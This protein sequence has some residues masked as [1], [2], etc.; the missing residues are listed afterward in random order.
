MDGAKLS[1]A[2]GGGAENSFR[3]SLRGKAHL[4]VVAGYL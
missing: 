2:P 1:S 3:S 4:K